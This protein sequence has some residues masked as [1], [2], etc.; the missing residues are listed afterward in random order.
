[1]IDQT[2]KLEKMLALMFFCGLFKTSF[3]EKQKRKSSFL[4]EGVRINVVKAIRSAYF[5]INDLT[6]GTSCLLTKF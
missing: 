4:K 1:M 3:S 2:S 5:Y 6:S